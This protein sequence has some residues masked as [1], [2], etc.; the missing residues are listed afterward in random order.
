MKKNSNINRYLTFLV[1]ASLCTTSTMSFAAQP[2]PKLVVNVVIDQLRSDYLEAFVP[3][4]CD[5]GFNKLLNEGRVYQ[6]AQN[7]FAPADRS[8]SCATIT[9]GAIPYYNG[10][11]SSSWLDR[12]TLRPVYGN[13]SRRL[14]TTTVGDELKVFTQGTSKVFSISPFSDAAVLLAGHAANDIMWVDDNSGAWVSV[15]K[16]PWVGA[17]QR[18]HSIAQ[19]VNS[20]KWQPSSVL[21]GNVS[22]F[23]GGG[24]RKPFSHSFDGPQRFVD[25]KRSALINKDVTDCALQCVESNAMGADAITDLLN[26]AYYAGTYKDVG[27]ADCQMELQDTYVRLDQQLSRLI[28]TLTTKFGKDNVLFVF[29]STGYSYPSKDDYQK[30]GIPSGTFYINRTAN[31][32]NMYLAAVYGQGQYVDAAYHSQIY[33]NHKLLEQKRIALSDILTRSRDFLCISDGIRD[34][35]TTDRILTPANQ[36]VALIRNAYNPI[37]CGD[38]IIEPAP[39]WQV[40]N[41]DNGETFTSVASPVVFPIIFYGSGVKAEQVLTPVTTDRIAPTISKCIRIRAPNACKSVPLF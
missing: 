14:L 9:T 22:Y 24:M 7:D 18:L 16:L 29:T 1:L 30:Y 5:G 28:S 11:V 37:L 8:N 31:L 10:V 2:L 15:N 17:F 12:E 25:Y 40:I 34:V 4:Y 20:E 19:K 39:G 3:L 38:I 26:V 13:S 21:S 27:L 41:E 23:M 36:D 33:L 32:L 6:Q 35:H